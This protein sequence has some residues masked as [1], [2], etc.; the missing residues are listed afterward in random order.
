MFLAEFLIFTIVINKATTSLQ[1]NLQR[2]V[3]FLLHVGWGNVDF[4]FRSGKWFTVATSPVRRV[5]VH[6][7]LFMTRVIRG[8]SLD[9]NTSDRE[10]RNM[11]TPINHSVAITMFVRNINRYHI[12]IFDFLNC[13]IINIIQEENIV[14]SKISIK[15][16]L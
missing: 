15:L 3:A 2:L 10:M 13:L 4:N 9:I 16:E 1:Y 12:Y 6:S 7:F 14:Y 5:L 8:L 11:D